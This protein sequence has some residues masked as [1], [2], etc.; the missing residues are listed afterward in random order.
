MKRSFKDDFNMMAMLLI[1]I[2]VAVN[3]VGFQLANVLRL[4][5]FLDTIGTI[6]V[7]VIAGPWVALLTGLITNLINGIF[8]PVYFPYALTSIAIGVGAGYLS[9]YGF[10][11][12]VPKTIISGIIITFIAVIVSAPITVFVFGGVTGN[13]SSLI[14]AAFLA[15]GQEL[16]SAVFS[17]SF[18]TEVADKVV[19][20]LIVYF[21]VKAMSD[22][23]L[24]KMNYGDLYMKR[25]NRK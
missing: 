6:I 15:S 20:V 21:I 24:S 5:I 11:K 13:T 25:N 2:A 23:Y 17:S 16:W 19:S 9:K 7:G 12:S 14:T 18:I 10:F 3:L 4:P 1:P 22:R 8:N